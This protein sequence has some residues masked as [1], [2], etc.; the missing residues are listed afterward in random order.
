MITIA[1]VDSSIADK[2]AADVVCDGV[3]D[4]ADINT[5]LGSGNVEVFLFNG[6]YQI[7]API[8]LP[9]GAILRGNAVAGVVL[10]CNTTDGVLRSSAPGSTHA[11]VLVESMRITAGTENDLGCD[12]RGFI[13]SQFNRLRVTSFDLGVWF[14]GDLTTYESCW[15]NV[16]SQFFLS[17]N[18]VGVR[19]SGV[20]SPGTTTAN[21]ITLFQGE[22]IC[23]D[24]SGAVAVDV[25]EG[26]ITVESCD[27]GYGDLSDGIVFHEGASACRVVNCR[28]EWDDQASNKYPIKI[29]EG[30]LFHYI[31]GNI[32]T[33]D[34]TVPNVYDAN[35]SDGRTT[36]IDVYANNDVAPTGSP[37]FNSTVYFQRNPAFAGELYIP[38]DANTVFGI[39]DGAGTPAFSVSTNFDRV[40]I[41]NGT[42][43]EL[44]DGTGTPTITFTPSDGAMSWAGNMI[45][46]GDAPTVTVGA[47]SGTGASALVFGSDSA[48]VVALNTG[49]SPS[50]GTAL[51]FTWS[52]AK[53]SDAY[54]VILTAASASGLTALQRVY[55]DQDNATDA[56]IAIIATTALPASAN[57]RLYYQVISF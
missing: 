46:T 31:V 47:A 37:I 39:A 8:D 11:H 5:A 40:R 30:S 6:N 16:F 41:A 9:D 1:A 12:L 50:T 27:I 52:T 19:F 25:I 53:P 57:I 51:T 48:G 18:L 36:Q 54:S 38:M 17:Q 45:S 32:F 26:E 49:T 28:F 7:D 2:A 21:N 34:C 4:Q 20:G 23:K 55:V 35:G 14:G 44:T 43:L 56:A 15:S 22:I 3:N 13:R 33:D 29:E 10:I 42:Y 24:A